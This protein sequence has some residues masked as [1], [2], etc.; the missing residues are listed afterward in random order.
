MMEIATWQ[1]NTKSESKNPNVDFLSHNFD[2]SSQNL[3]LMLIFHYDKRLF[4]FSFVLMAK[5]SLHGFR[6][7]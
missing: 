3:A 7:I 4:W 1:Q 2:F 5:I 6:T